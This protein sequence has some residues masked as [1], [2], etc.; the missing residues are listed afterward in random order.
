V[1]FEETMDEMREGN[2]VSF[3]GIN[4]PGGKGAKFQVDR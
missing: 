4:G 1:F 2:R 3:T